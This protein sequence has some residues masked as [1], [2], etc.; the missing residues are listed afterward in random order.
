MRV[1]RECCAP[2]ARPASERS[3]PRRRARTSTPAAA[4]CVPTSPLTSSATD[5]PA[6]DRNA[7]STSGSS[8]AS[9][10]P[11]SGTS[12]ARAGWCQRSL[13]RLAQRGRTRRCCSACTSDSTRCRLKIAS[14][15]R[16]VSGKRRA[17]LRRGQTDG[18]R[19]HDQPQLVGPR[20]AQ[21]DRIA[22][23]PPRSTE[24]RPP[25]SAGAALSA[26]PSTAV[27]ARQQHRRQATGSVTRSNMRKPGHRRGGAAAETGRHRDVARHLDLD[28]RR[29]DARSGGRS[30]R[31]RARRR[32]VRCTGGVLG[33]T[34]SRAPP[35]SRTSTIRARRYS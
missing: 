31:T 32:S 10:S 34:V 2:D 35:S 25:N 11:S 14:R 3:R 4:R 12:D 7:P 16:H 6:P 29:A 30:R 23:A 26:C 18:R 22:A 19:R 24:F 20:P 8:I 13:H 28:R 17:R 33:A 27:A 1:R 9:T 15:A 5:G 21:R